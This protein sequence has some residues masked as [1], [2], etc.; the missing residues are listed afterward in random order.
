MVRSS[1][2][3]PYGPDPEDLPAWLGKSMDWFWEN[4]K[5]GGHRKA[6][7]VPDWFWAGFPVPIFPV[8]NQSRMRK[9]GENGDESHKKCHCFGEID[10]KAMV[11]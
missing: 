7:M 8:Q 6:E 4:L 1:D 2:V 10:E 9:N 3:A 5:T 11:S